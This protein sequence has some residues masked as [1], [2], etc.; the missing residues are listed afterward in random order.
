[1]TLRHEPSG[2]LLTRRHFIKKFGLL[3]AGSA[4][5]SQ[6]L[7]CNSDFVIPC[8]GP[9]PPPT[10][11]PGMTY[12][13][14]SEIGCALDCDL[15]NGRNK[16]NAGAAT[17]DGPRINEAMAKATADNPITLIIDGSALISGLFLPTGGHWNIAGLGCGTGFFVK[18][19]TNNDG[20]HNG[21]AAVISN[22]PGPPAPARGMNVSLKN[23]TLNGNQGNGHDGNSTSGIRQGSTSAW[24]FGLNLVNLENVVIENVVVVRTSAYHIQ[25]SNVGHVTVRGCVLHSDGLSTDGLHFN[26]PAND[27]TISNCDFRTGDDSIALNCPEGYSG[28]ISRVEVSNCTFNS[29][30]L[31]RLYTTNWSPRTF[32]IDSVTVRDCNAILAEGAFL[33]GLSAGSL[34]ESVASLTVSDCKLTAPTILAMAE[35]FGTVII[36]RTTFTPLRSRVVWVPPQANDFSGFMRPSPLCGYVPCFGSSLT[37]EN[38]V[39][40]RIG[41]T[42]VPAVV[43]ANGSRIDL[44]AFRG[45]EVED[46]GVSSLCQ[47]Y[48]LSCRD[49]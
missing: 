8:L 32:K 1:M 46:A 45:F 25:L 24:Y 4:V 47:S 3:A 6:L 33:I 7:G 22:N 41:N 44:L 23:F 10:P 29:W 5:G 31:M 37:F 38:C 34:P 2:S 40:K 15:K 48:L 11:V 49:R 17:D 28:D 14:A 30:S 16:H 9:A 13:R 39:V 26:G 27:I 42:A 36:R 19:G 12:I 18:T 20:I 35:N 21:P 43:L